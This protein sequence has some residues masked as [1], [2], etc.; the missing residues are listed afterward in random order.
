M[1]FCTNFFKFNC[2]FSLKYRFYRIYLTAYGGTKNRH[3]EPTNQDYLKV[4]LLHT[5]LKIFTTYILHLT[6]QKHHLQNP[7]KIT[8]KHPFFTFEKHQHSPTQTTQSTTPIL[9]ITYLTTYQI[10]TQVTPIKHQVTLIQN[11]P[12][13]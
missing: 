10:T 11:S 4:V 2:I 8:Q 12:H 3:R 7:L 5:D 9:N 13:T 6:T 1:F